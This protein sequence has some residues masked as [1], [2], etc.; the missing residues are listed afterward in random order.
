MSKSIVDTLTGLR[1]VQAG[2]QD[3][4]VKLPIDKWVQITLSLMSAQDHAQMLVNKV[5]GASMSSIPIKA[6]EVLAGIEVEIHAQI[7]AQVGATQ[8]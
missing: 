8:Q 6:V 7:R 1:A 3:Y 2:K 5:G 4:S